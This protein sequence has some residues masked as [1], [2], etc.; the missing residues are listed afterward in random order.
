MVEYATG[1]LNLVQ[2]GYKAVWWKLFYCP[3]SKKWS[4]VLALVELLFC[5]P[6]AN[7]R[8]ERAFFHLNS[9]KAI[10]GGIL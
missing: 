10:A 1:Y 3:D 5:L 4:N 7:G 9:S 8:L 6:M 2:D